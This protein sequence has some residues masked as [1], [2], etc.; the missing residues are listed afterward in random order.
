MA[1]KLPKLKISR[2]EKR[3]ILVALLAILFFIFF[4]NL[5]DFFYYRP[6]RIRSRIFH[7]RN[8]L[9]RSQLKVK[10]RPSLEARVAASK[11]KVSNIQGRLLPGEK[12]PVA[13]ARL[14]QI[15]EQTAK[16][17]NVEIKSQKINQPK[18]HPLVLEIPVEVVFVCYVGELKNFLYRIESHPKLLTI[19]KWSIRVPNHRDPKQIQVNMT[20]AG[21]IVKT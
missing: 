13:A 18:E 8:I 1:W 4:D 15:I 2:R 21:F 7:E 12:P 20:I 9:E 19:P 10:S 14:Q 11:E 3:L 5:A 16:E 6:Q 17:T